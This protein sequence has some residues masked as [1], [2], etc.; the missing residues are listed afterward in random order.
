VMTT[1]ALYLLYRGTELEEP[2]DRTG[3]Y[4]VRKT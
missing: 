3:F 4:G 2:I 1:P